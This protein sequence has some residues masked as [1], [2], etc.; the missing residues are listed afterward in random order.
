MFY[1]GQKVVFVG[2]GR[3][4][5][6]YLWREIKQAWD[7]FWHPYDDPKI[8]N[9]YTIAKIDVYE[10]GV[11]LVLVEHESGDLDFWDRGWYSDGFRPIVERKTDIS[12]FT[13]MLKNEKINA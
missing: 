4:C 10:E 11:V 2:Y 6:D 8:G 1:V 3:D 13:S 9:I 5:R 12:I 7:R